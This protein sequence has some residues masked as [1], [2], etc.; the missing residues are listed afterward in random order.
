MNEIMDKAL[1]FGH[2]EMTK[3]G[4]RPAVGW[5]CLLEMM[6][7]NDIHSVEGEADFMVDGDTLT[8]E[9]VKKIYAAPFFSSWTKG[10]S[11]KKTLFY[12]TGPNNA[13][14]SCVPYYIRGDTAYVNLISEDF[15]LWKRI[16]F[17][18]LQ[19]KTYKGV[20]YNIPYD[21]IGYLEEYYG[22]PWDDFEGRKNWHWKQGLNHVLLKKFP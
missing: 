17:D 18:T 22:K 19:T 3:L 7:W 10:I 13:R 15:F 4:I 14:V 21:F 1:Q 5:S 8:D 20:Q 12:L 9:V 2:E 16:H 6:A 11:D